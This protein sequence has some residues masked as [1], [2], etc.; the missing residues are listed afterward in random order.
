MAESITS[1]IAELHRLS[2]SQLR[3]KMQRLTGEPCRQTHR[4]YLIKRL[5]FKIQE[6]HYGGL[7]EEAKDQITELR[8]EFEGT[9]PGTWFNPPAKHVQRP[10]RRLDVNGRDP[11]LPAPG[12]TLT[13]D[14]RGT[15]YSV[16]VTGDGFTFEG[17]PFK[18]LSGVAQAICGCHVNG[19]S[20]FRLNQGS[21]S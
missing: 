20:F 13:R 7:S 1:Q 12:T 9:T 14:Y 6:L 19:F 17:Q 21:N 16:E 4:K 15:E 3:K 10:A 11:R 18:S 5:A 2:V 8:K